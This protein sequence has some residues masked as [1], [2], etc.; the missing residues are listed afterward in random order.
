MP[1]IQKGLQKS[2][3]LIK[4]FLG[5]HPIINFFIDQLNIGQIISSCIKQD[6]RLTL[7]LDKSLIVLIHNILTSPMPMYEILDWSKT[8]D[9][10]S[11]GLG[12]NEA[13][14]L[15]DDRIGRALKTFYDGKHKDVFFRL[16]LRAIKMHK[17]N[18]DYVH[19]D[20]T[21]ITLTGKYSSQQAYE[22]ITFGKNKDH[23]PD[24]KQLVLGLSVTAD[25]AVPLAHKVYNGNQTDDTLHIENH[26]KL[27]KLLKRTDFIYV[28]DSKLATESNLDSIDA[29]NGKF[30][31]IM[32]RTWSED[33]EFK[34]LVNQGSI[35]WKHILSKRNNKA[36][37]KKFDKYFLANGVYWAKGKYRLIWLKSSQKVEQDKETRERRL[38]KCL[39]EIN[40]L[41]IK[42]NKRKLKK[43][44]NIKNAI[45]EITK[46]NKCT[47]LINF[48][49]CSTRIYSKNNKKLMSVDTDKQWKNI[50]SIAF[51]LNEKAIEEESLVDGHR[52]SGF[53]KS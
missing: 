40:A 1:I 6:E 10:E 23:R 47:N 20:T 38:Q 33:K 19:Q 14:L 29:C 41:S 52:C 31:S 43:R 35:N 53:L 26:R 22:K 15:N 18:C 8:L 50:F 28:A 9:E 3:K 46:K 30:I 34:T 39:E 21:S 11:V 4:R 49:I 17:L 32:P 2:S 48:E 16:A 13:E 24:L 37:G 45:K 27:V 7:P 51:G 44:V 42:L 36:Y 25:G 12:K 5:A